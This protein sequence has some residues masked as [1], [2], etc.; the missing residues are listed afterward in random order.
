[1]ILF[2]V[3]FFFLPV[4]FFSL[5]SSSSSPP[6]V[7]G[8]PG[9]NTRACNIVPSAVTIK[10]ACCACSSVIISTGRKFTTVGIWY[11]RG[12]RCA[13]ASA[14]RTRAGTTSSDERLPHR[15]CRYPRAQRHLHS[16]RV[17]AG[18]VAVAAAAWVGSKPYHATHALAAACAGTLWPQQRRRHRSGS[19]SVGV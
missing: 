9:I 10:V 2:L 1:M 11:P 3:F 8:S 12:V 15:H 6:P 13:A 18:T 19:S 7:P 16:T 17:A 5:F 4:P 14:D